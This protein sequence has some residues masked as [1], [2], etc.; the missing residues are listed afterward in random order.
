MKRMSPLAVVA[1]WLGFGAWVRPAHP[2]LRVCFAMLAGLAP[3]HEE[4][5]ASRGRHCGPADPLAFYDT[6]SYGPR[7]I[8]AMAAAVGEDALVFGSDRPVVAPS[9]PPAHHASRAANPARLFSLQE[10]HA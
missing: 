2:G 10:V 1:A 8:A 7:A 5:L 4:R 6:S 9:M 3:L